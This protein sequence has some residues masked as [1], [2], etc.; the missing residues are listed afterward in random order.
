MERAARPGG[1]EGDQVGLRAVPGREPPDAHARSARGWSAPTGRRSRSTEEERRA[2]YERRWERGGLPFLGAFTDLLLDKAANDTA[3]EFVREKLH[4]IVRDP[5]TA[6][7]LTPDQVVGCK[8]LCVDTGYWDTFNQPHVHLVDLRESPI[9]AITPTGIQTTAE[10]HDLDVLIYATGFD[11]MTGALLRIDIRGRG[12]RTLQ[13]A[14][15]AG[16]A[17]LPRPRRGGV[18]EPLHHHR[19]RAARRCSPTCS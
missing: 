11:A 6:R 8:R 16:P 1:G 4:E 3:A 19:A 2:E 14:W 15:A 13:D 17:H 10:H 5:D 18:P 9:E 7:K 12:G